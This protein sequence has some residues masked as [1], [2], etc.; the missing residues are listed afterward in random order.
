[1]KSLPFKKAKKQKSKKAK[2]QKS[3]KAKKQKNKNKNKIL[4]MAWGVSGLVSRRISE[5]NL[6]LNKMY[7]SSH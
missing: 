7:D 5:R 4:N 3:K 6:F 2:K 1:M